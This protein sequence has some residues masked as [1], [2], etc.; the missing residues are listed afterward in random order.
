VT[1][2][3][4]PKQQPLPNDFRTLFVDCVWNVMARAQKPH[5]VFRQNGQVHLN[6]RSC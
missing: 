3:C 4:L 2:C 5:F 1:P 6:Q